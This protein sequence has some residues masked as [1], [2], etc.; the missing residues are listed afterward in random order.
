M[1]APAF[2]VKRNQ[3]WVLGGSGRVYPHTGP[4]ACPGPYNSAEKRMMPPGCKVSKY[5]AR[6]SIKGWMGNTNHQ[7]LTNGV[8]RETVIHN[9]TLTR[10]L[11][12]GKENPTVPRQSSN[13]YAISTPILLFCSG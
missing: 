7:A 11:I 8:L 9:H 10:R 2:G 1:D 13:K 12:R 3:G 6:L 5:P 4:G